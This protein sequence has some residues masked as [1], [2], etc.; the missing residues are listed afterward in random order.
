MNLKQRMEHRRVQAW[1]N[2]HIIIESLRLGNTSKI[3]KSNHQ[4]NTTM[5]AKPCLECHVYKF[6][7]HLQGWGLK[8]LPGKPVAMLSHS[9]SKE[10]FPTIQFKPPLMQLEAVASRPITSYLGEE[11]N[12]CLTTTSFQVVGESNKVPP[13]PPLL[14][15]RQPQLLQPLLVRFVL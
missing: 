7:E 10:I 4:P 1:G 5:P 6:F 3:S 9:C 12:I 2:H 13:Q 8:H 14:Q 11:T 15:N